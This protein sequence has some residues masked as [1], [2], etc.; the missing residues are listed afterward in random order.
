MEK[1]KLFTFEL[2]Y[3]PVDVSY[4]DQNKEFWTEWNEFVVS[5]S[6]EVETIGKVS[7]YKLAKERANRY[8]KELGIQLKFYVTASKYEFYYCSNVY[9][10]KKPKLN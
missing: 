10:S 4:H 1:S 7:A 6:E 9:L 5:R 8:A 3:A 2:H